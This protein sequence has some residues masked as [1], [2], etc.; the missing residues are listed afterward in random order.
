MGQQHR[1]ALAT[2]AAA[3]TLAVIVTGCST[4]G[5]SADGSSTV[6]VMLWGNDQDIS[7]IKDAAAGFETAHPEITIEWETGDCGVDYATC[8]TLAAGDTLPDA[9]VMGTWGYY[10]AVRDGLIADVTPYLEK[11]GIP[12]SGLH[13]SG[14]RR[15]HRRRRWAVRPADGL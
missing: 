8:K 6:R 7:S 1:R 14:H 4:G 3:A 10:D 9:F 15:A 2:L 11:A 13:R 5:D 12:K